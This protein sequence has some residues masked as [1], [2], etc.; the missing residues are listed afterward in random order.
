MTK[1][2]TLADKLA[3]LPIRYKAFLIAYV[4]SATF[5][6]IEAWC[7]ARFNRTYVEVVEELR[8]RYTKGQVAAKTM[9][10]R[11]QAHGVWKNIEKHFGGLTELMDF[12]GLDNARLIL[13]H[14]K[15][16]NAQKP[17]INHKT[18]DIIWYDDG[19]TQVKNL[20]LLHEVRGNIVEKKQHEITHGGG[21]PLKIDFGDP[22][23]VSLDNMTINGEVEIPAIASS[24]S[25]EVA[26]V[27]KRGPGRPRKTPPVKRT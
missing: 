2:L 12:M 15:L 24:S 13:E 1:E 22:N 17:M 16:L 10:I 25:G 4:Q 9:V 7:L 5:D 6:K 18:G 11:G 19:S 26:T 20:Q 21:N 23:D 14:Q 8:S 27:V 3:T